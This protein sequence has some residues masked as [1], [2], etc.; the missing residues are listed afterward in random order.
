MEEIGS[1]SEEDIRIVRSLAS[2][3]IV[4]MRD[5]ASIAENPSA[6]DQLINDITEAYNLNEIGGDYDV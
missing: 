6:A 5:F 2:R 3:E 1:I 4:R